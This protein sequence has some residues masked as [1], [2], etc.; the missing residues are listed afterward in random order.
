MPA[1][2]CISACP[3]SLRQLLRVCNTALKLNST[4][5]DAFAK[6]SLDKIMIAVFLGKSARAQDSEMT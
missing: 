6:C 4:P 2:E 1:C 5:T 3:L